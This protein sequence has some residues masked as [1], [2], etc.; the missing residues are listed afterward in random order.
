MISVYHT[1]R[2]SYSLRTFAY[3]ITHTEFTPGYEE[4]TDT[5]TDSRVFNLAQ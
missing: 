2:H 5:L 4:I 3:E 1:Q